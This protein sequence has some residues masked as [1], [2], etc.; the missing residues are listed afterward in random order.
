MGV[1]FGSKYIAVNSNNLSECF[2]EQIDLLPDPDSSYLHETYYLPVPVELN[3]YPVFDNIKSAK[4]KVKE[5][6][7]DKSENKI[8]QTIVAIESSKLDIDKLR[9][10]KERKDWKARVDTIKVNIKEMTEKL[11][12]LKT[13][14]RRPVPESRHQLNKVNLSL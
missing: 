10:F 2:V 3:S 7:F 11:T 9:T 4:K 5:H 1:H 14:R 13:I 8:I 12:T 6:I